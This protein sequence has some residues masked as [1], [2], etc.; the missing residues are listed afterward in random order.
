MGTNRRPPKK[1][2]YGGSWIVWYRS[3]ST[4]VTRPTRMPAKT[5]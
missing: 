5:L 2:R 4:A 3:N 1:P